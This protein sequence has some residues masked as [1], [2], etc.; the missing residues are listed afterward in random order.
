MKIIKLG[1]PAE[2]YGGQVYGDQIIKL[3]SSDYEIV[4]SELGL[5]NKSRY[6]KIFHVLYGLFKFRKR[7]D[8]D[9]VI[10]EFDSCFFFNKKPVKQIV[11]IHHIDY[12]FLPLVYKIGYSLLKRIIYSNARRADAIFIDKFY[13]Y[14]Q[15]RSFE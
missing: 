15:L 3:L 4:N 10:R 12:R 9:F 11:I 13:I 1:I 7:N 2:Q 6:S 5:P 8:C 14:I